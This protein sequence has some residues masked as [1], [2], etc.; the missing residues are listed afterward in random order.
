M[1]TLWGLALAA[2]AWGQAPTATV[3]GRIEDASKASLPEVKVQIR[4]KNT[5]ESREILTATDGEFAATNL[6]PGLY[7]LFA[8]KPGFKKVHETEFELQVDQTARFDLRMMVGDVSE[9]VEVRDEV[10]LLNTENATRGEVIVTQE[11][12]EMPL[13]GR[14]F[15]DLTF[16]VPGV[17]RRAQ[18]GS[19]SALN[20]NGARS[21]NTSFLIDGFANNNMRSG[22]AQARPPIDALQE[23]KLQ[24]NGYPAEYGRRAGGVMTMALKTGTNQLHG[25]LFEFARDDAFDARNFFDAEKS[26]LRR[27][28]FGGTLHGPILFPRVY[29]GRNRTFFLGSWESYRQTQGVT[30]LSRVPTQ[31]ERFG[32]FSQTKDPTTGK[33]IGLKDPVGNT[34]FP[35]NLIPASRIHLVSRNL[36]PFYPAPNAP[37]QVNNSRANR[38]DTDHWDSFLGKLDHRL[39]EKDNLSGR[40]MLRRNDQGN[41]FGGSDTGLFGNRTP[42]RLSLGGVTWTRLWTPAL[43][44][45]LRLGFSRQ[46]QKAHSIQYGTD[47][48]ARLGLPS[49]SNPE[50]YGFPRV[51]VRDLVALGNA[52]DQPLRYTMSDIELGG[53]LT[54]VRDRHIWKFG[55]DVIQMQYFQP[56]LNNMRGTF[57]FLGR[58]TSDPFADFLL[59]YLNNATRKTNGADPQLISWMSGLFVQDD[60]RAGRS[61]T[62]NLGLR[63]EM[64]LPMSDRRGRLANFVPEYGKIAIADRNSLANLDQVIQEAGL[65][66]KIGY[67]SDYGLPRSIVRPNRGMIAPR[68]GFAWRPRA[69]NRMA[70]RGGYGVFYTASLT[71]PVRGDLADVFPFSVNQ[72]FN[73]QTSDPNTV[74]F[75]TPFPANRITLD[76]VTN[77]SGFQVWQPAPYLQSWNMTVE[78]DLGAATAIEIAYVGSKG[79]H[80]GR[81][82]NVNQ[83]F[84]DPAL[85]PTP[86]GSFP[87]PY[88][89]INDVTYY[90]FGS[91]SNY[92]A[93]I[94]TWRRRFARG[95][96]F[97]INYVYSKS[98]DDASQLSGSGDGGYGGAQDARN[99]SLEHGRSDFD[100]GHAMTMSFSWQPPFRRS[101]WTRGWQVTGSGRAYTGQPLT[102]KTSNVQLDQG[103]ANR[104]DRVA[105]G[106]V[107][108]PTPERWFDLSAFPLVPAGAFR[109]GNSGRNI[110]D[111]PGFAGINFGLLR[112]F[113]TGERSYLQLRWE[114]F[115]ILN[116]AN[117]NLP[118][119]NVNAATGGTI[120][121]AD[122]P[123]V[124]QLAAK[125]VF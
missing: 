72:T 8:E 101:R 124:M 100:N 4:N 106:T 6:A 96:F 35:G 66:A 50:T 1:R 87:R 47:W 31:L 53:S 62:L 5:G 82:Y 42:E 23:Y 12:I 98:I 95:F 7:E 58:W 45:E 84:R 40:Y 119:V 75:S 125:W 46:A 11:I 116:R 97:R 105:K 120:T 22:G 33:I 110:L 114:V 83:P 77:S 54:L 81:R 63:Y 122:P 123:R 91:N 59:G 78:R 48:N 15:N 41:P 25:T 44:H 34:T 70:V 102:A 109:F 111:G 28:Q 52:A 74:S 20:I 89:G 113:K 9:S 19:G 24:T 71:N 85:R 14:D 38:A 61:L 55:G 18:G 29:N 103:E 73:R 56:S 65:A 112:R 57:N 3:V 80:L 21:D 69:S 68:F 92:H 2:A 86:S 94:L 13:E 79:T 17:A 67:A 107:E 104:P 51:T 90:A 108:H 39:N 49:P 32:D 121:E 30:R 76:G 60:W 43:I 115:N 117:F 99:L 93:G 88:P 36:L 118:N 10:P 37:G 16:M 26:D 64:N 27:N